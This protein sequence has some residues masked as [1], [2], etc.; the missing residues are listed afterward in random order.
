MPKDKRPQVAPAW[1]KYILIAFI[2]YA[3]FLHFTNNGVKEAE[4]NAAV[5][6]SGAVAPRA[7]DYRPVNTIAVG[8]DIPGTGEE[9]MCGQ[10]A[11]AKATGKY[12]D[13]TVI[14][15]SD[16]AKE[17]TLR[18]GGDVKEYAWSPGLVGMKAGGIREILLPASTLSEDILETKKLEE[19]AKL[20]Y[21]VELLSLSPT[22]PVGMVSFR[23]AEITIGRGSQVL[24]GDMIRIQLDL[25]GPDGTLVYSTLRD[26]DKKP[27]EIRVGNSDMFYGLDRGLM[28]MREGGGRNLVIPPAYVVSRAKEGG[29]FTKIIE[30]LPKDAIV[31]ADVTVVERVTR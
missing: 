15:G 24:C 18:I 12:P 1:L 11:V 5:V 17:M 2:G 28:G 19:N 8:G 9:A 26:N 3:M 7:S 29:S 25:W 13:G 20:Q 30:K 27:L 31:L 16:S 4:Q 14:E 6:S 22:L 10:T 23:A 21:R